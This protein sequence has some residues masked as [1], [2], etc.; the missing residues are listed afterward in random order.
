MLTS[1]I[2]HGT[3]SAI[4]VN[5]LCHE[6][7]AN[8]KCNS[9]VL[10]K[11]GQ[12][13]QGFTNNASMAFDITETLTSTLSMHEWMGKQTTAGPIKHTIKMSVWEKDRSISLYKGIV[14]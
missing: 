13:A 14:H 10:D 1:S 2:T 4:E 5:Y 6:T 8:T 11:N 3:L 12:E 9:S 7:K